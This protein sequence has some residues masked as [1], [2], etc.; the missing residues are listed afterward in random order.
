MRHLRFLASLAM[1]L[2]AALPIKAQTENEAFYIYQNDGHFDGFFYDEIV[3]MNFSFLDTLGI[4]HDEIVSQEIV[5]PDSTYRIMLSAIDSIGFVQ[6]E[7]KYNP[8]LHNNLWRNGSDSDSYSYSD[9]STDN[10]SVNFTFNEEDL[11]ITYNLMYVNLETWPSP[12]DVFLYRGSERLLY[13]D[14]WAVKVVSVEEKDYW[15]VLHCK[16]IDDITDIFQQ[17]VSIEEYGYRP[18]GELARRRVAGRPDLSVGEF[19]RKASSGTWEG[20][21]FNFSIAGHI[22]LYSKDDLSITIDPSIEGKLNIKTAWNLSLWGD[23][24]IGITSAL[25]FGVSIGFT[26]DGTIDTFFP[27]GIGGLLSG[28]PVPAACPLLMLDIAPDCF[29]RGDAHVK[30]NAKSPK[31]NGGMW[32]KLEINNWVP[33]MDLGFGKPNGENFNAYDSSSSGASL[34]LSGFV[35]AGLWFPMK[36]RTMP[37]LKSFFE[38][39]IGGSWFVGPKLAGSITLDSSTFPT[40]GTATYNLLKNTKLQLHMLDAD[41]EVKAK[42]NTWL[43]GK[44]EVTLT[45]GSISIFPP[46]DAAL[47]PEF[48]SVETAMEERTITEDYVFH[49]TGSWGSSWES[50]EGVRVPCRT[51]YIPP[52]GAVVKP[53]TI[54]TALYH[55]EED[56]TETMISSRPQKSTSYYHIHQMMGQEVPKYA[57]AK[58]D[59]LL[60][61]NLEQNPYHRVSDSDTYEYDH[62]HTVLSS[63]SPKLRIRPIVEAFGQIY[64]ADP[65]YDFQDMPEITLSGDTLIALHDGTSQNEVTISTDGIPFSNS[66]VS[67]SENKLSLN[68]SYFN[69]FFGKNY[70]LINKA[71]GQWRTIADHRYDYV[72]F[73]SYKPVSIEI[74]PNTTENP[75]IDN[76][77]YSCSR[78]DNGHGWHF[79]VT[80]NQEWLN[81]DGKKTIL[82]TVSFDLEEIPSETVNP[83]TLTEFEAYFK[84]RYM[85]KNFTEVYEIS[86]KTET[87]TRN[88]WIVSLNPRSGNFESGNFDDFIF[89][90]TRVLIHFAK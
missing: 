13:E 30:F 78:M 80:M 51:F 90:D 66:L 71:V 3:K 48:G 89:G 36:Y 65:Y 23:K 60:T 29:L 14:G 85:I 19:T 63:D 41:Y 52:S 10:W 55:V 4:E 72:T 8:R 67:L 59:H 11:T 83:L 15:M 69:E 76:I 62:N 38:S 87:E 26:V 2:L 34:E 35:Q 82:K 24:Y 33:S 79:H 53:V 46:L 74:L 50:L 17:F 84:D 88:D 61:P 28:V 86:G 47:A 39:E 20:D 43:S 1:M 31:L 56:G 25:S 37:I 18:N 68:K 40:N 42:V 12:G 6:P 27:G 44:Q 9:E 70:S 64:P 57:W 77:T 54:A 45:D 21:L 7:V 58:Y 73:R 32:A 22:P 81:L 49:Q 5:T 75:V 16:P